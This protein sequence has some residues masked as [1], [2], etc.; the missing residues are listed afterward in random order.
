MFRVLEKAFPNRRSII[1]RRIVPGIAGLSIG[2][3]CIV[4]ALKAC[5]S[6][7]IIVNWTSTYQTIDGFGASS[8]GDVYKLSSRLM[9]AFYST[10]GP[11]IGLDFIRLKIYPDYEDCEGDEGAGHCVKVDAGPTL[12]TWDLAN[13]QAAV[14]RGAKVVVGEWSPPGSMKSNGKYQGGGAFIG[15]EPNYRKLASIQSDFVVMLAKKYQISI[16]SISPQNEPDMSQPSYPSCTW[17]AQQFHDYVP[18]LA[19]ALD[20]AG[21]SGV[22]IMLSEK[23]TWANSYDTVA[24]NDPAVAAKIDI[25][26]E[27]AYGSSP[28]ILTWSNLSHQH[29][30]ETEVSDFGTPDGSIA[31]ALIYATQIHNWLTEVGVNAWFWWALDDDQGEGKNCC[32]ADSTGRLTKR[33]Y[34]IGNWSK[35]VRPDWQRIGVTNNGPLLVSAFKGT[36]K[37]FA[38]VVVNNSRWP[39]LNQEFSLNGLVL[40]GFHVI[41]WVTSDS[42]SLAARA[43]IECHSSCADFQYSIPAKSIVTFQGGTE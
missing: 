42:A 32:L 27:H 7:P 41:P 22:K 38:I 11:G 12:S 14:A 13:A 26:A 43:P 36:E 6:D 31:S 30:W 40:S 35:F 19:E 9:D 29:I 25:L 23:S 28:S 18:Y 2:L 15:N 3:I 24:M 4:F 21:Y 17:T 20:D 16:Y 1:R 8:G 10:A 37:E 33:A 39:V 34:A 5:A